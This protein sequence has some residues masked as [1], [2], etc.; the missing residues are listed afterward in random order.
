MKTVLARSTREFKVKGKTEERTEW[1]GQSWGEREEKWK[2]YW[3]CQDQQRALEWRLLPRK[4]LSKLGLPKKKEWPQ[5]HKG[6]S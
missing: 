2:I 3:C 4:N 5:C 6:S 1:R